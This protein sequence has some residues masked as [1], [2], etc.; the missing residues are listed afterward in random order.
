[1]K[2]RC[3]DT[4]GMSLDS[5]EEVTARQP[6]EAQ[7]IIRLLL[8]KISDWEAPVSELQRRQKSPRNSSLPPSM[9]HP[10]PPSLLSAA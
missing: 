6:P 10:C 9:Q 2:S 5:T 4:R 7:T 3:G 8:V 1:M